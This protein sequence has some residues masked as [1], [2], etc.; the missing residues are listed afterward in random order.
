M[1]TICPPLE[2][3]ARIIEKTKYQPERDYRLC[4]QCVVQPLP[5]GMLLFH[6]LT[7]ELLLLDAEEANRLADLPG[8]VPE[9]L[10]SLI[11]KRFLV[12][13]DENENAYCEQL[14]HIVALTNRK[15][16]AITSYTILPTSDCNARCF[17]CYELGRSRIP[18]SMET[19]RLAAAYIAAHCKGEKV[20]LHW[21]GG[22][23]LFN[24]PAIDAIINGLNDQGVSY[25]SGMISNGYLFDEALVKK[26]KEE[27]RLRRIQITLDGT[28]PVY[29]QRKAYI[30]REGSAY[31]RVLRN[32]RLLLDAEIRVSIRLNL[33]M[34]NKADLIALVDELAE[35]FAGKK[36][37]S[38]YDHIIFERP[39]NPRSA[40]ERAELYRASAELTAHI[41][42]RKMGADYGV[43]RLFRTNWCMADRAAATTI[44]PDGRLGKCEHYSESETWGALWSDEK[45]E[46]MLSDW[47]RRMPPLPACADCFYYPACIRLDK[48]PNHFG[49]CD[50]EYRSQRKDELQRQMLISFERWN[51]KQDNNEPMDMRKGTGAI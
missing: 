44:L 43:P 11:R 42:K 47:Q 20:A 24:L 13:T 49:Y 48:C 22:E 5:A 23:P 29:N 41:R 9:C 32:I 8:K 51:A 46:K 34:N 25:S 12:P 7:L 30:Y 4:R 1:T 39:E 16:D 40:E 15:S 3:L 31:R 33:D 10:T 36:G 6:T 27:W 38:I 14:R 17:Y 35:R 45:D 19:A 37:L 18:M 2:L 50:P 26:A 28:E 21:F